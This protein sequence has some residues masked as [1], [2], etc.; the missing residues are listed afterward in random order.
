MLVL[1]LWILGK[2]KRIGSGG[3]HSEKVFGGFWWC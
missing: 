1:Y 2:S 3:V